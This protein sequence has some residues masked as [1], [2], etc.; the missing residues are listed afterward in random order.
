[1]NVPLSFL[2]SNILETRPP[3]YTYTIPKCFILL[4]KAGNLHHYSSFRN[5]FSLVFPLFPKTQHI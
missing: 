4:D 3:P 1:M 2:L 5:G